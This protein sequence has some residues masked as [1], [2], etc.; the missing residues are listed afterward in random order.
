[1]PIERR[2]VDPKAHFL[3]ANN[4]S[5]KLL[6]WVKAK[7]NIGNTFYLFYFIYFFSLFISQLY[8]GES[9]THLS[10]KVM[11]NL[12][13]LVEKSW[14]FF[15][16]FFGNPDRAFLRYPS[17]YIAP[18]QYSTSLLVMSGRRATLSWNQGRR[19]GFKS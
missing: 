1:M 14:I 2:P 19:S 6:Y 18:V 12:N 16:Y 8:P 15:S 7:G 10:P 3:T 9:A 17:P 13:F 11:E 5:T 4:N